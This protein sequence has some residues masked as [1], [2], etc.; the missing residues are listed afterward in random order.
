M[1]TLNKLLHHFKNIKKERWIIPSV[2]FAFSVLLW[3]IL[4]RVDPNPLVIGLLKSGRNEILYLSPTEFV[5]M[6]FTALR[7]IAWISLAVSILT[8]MVAWLRPQT[9]IATSVFAFG[10]IFYALSALFAI[11]EQSGAPHYVYLADAFLHGES[12]LAEEPPYPDENDWTYY[13]GEWSVSF[14]PSPAILM[15]PF[16]AIW[17]LDFN[18]V[19][20][21]LLLGAVNLALIYQLLG[22]VYYRD[23]DLPVS[24]RLLLTSAFGF[25]TVHWWLSTNGQ[26]WFTAQIVATTFLLLALLETF[27]DQRPWLVALWLGLAALARPTILFALPALIWLLHPRRRWKELATGAL[28]LLLIGILMAA[29]NQARYDDPFELGYSYMQLENLLTRRVAESGSFNIVYLKGNFHHAF[30][31]LPEWRNT[32]PYLIMDGWG[33]SLVISTP[34][35]IFAFFAPW[36]EKSSQA[37]ALA[38]LLVAIPNLLYYNT[39]YLQAGYRY[40]LDFL[41]FL[42]ILI[43]LA[44]RG[45]APLLGKA[46]V[47]LSILTGFLMW[48]NFIG[49]AWELF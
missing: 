26:V 29:Y 3:V 6:V 41:P 1:S 20:F 47:I 5:A 37:M 43:A 32:F 9:L 27:G 49:L 17:G 18:D 44:W 16:V 40:A 12:V 39:G 22:R 35:L 31:N 8:P 33:L 45:S 23:K 7:T 36:R 2:L 46:L 11:S 34:L 28:P 21:T 42:F 30:L 38:A 13:Q 15:M 25:G 10:A 4:L 19:I 14:P 48:A 24:A